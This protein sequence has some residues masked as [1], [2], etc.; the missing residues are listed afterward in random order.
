MLLE[1]NLHAHAAQFHIANLV[2][3]YS[4][5]LGS[6]AVKS[7][8]YNAVEFCEGAA[9][10]QSVV[11]RKVCGRERGREGPRER[12]GGEGQGR[13]KC[14]HFHACAFLPSFRHLTTLCGHKIT[15]SDRC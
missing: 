6:S 13:E 4:A 12:E 11:A 5:R 1:S 8:D 9:V 15:L 14:A 10:S 2:V 7:G 3:P